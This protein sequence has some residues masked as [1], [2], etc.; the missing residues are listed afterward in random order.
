MRLT[1]FYILFKLRMRYCL[2]L[3]KYLE[4][5]LNFIVTVF[6][7]VTEKQIFYL[8]NE[9]TQLDWLTRVN[10]KKNN[11][12]CSPEWASQITNIPVNIINELADKII[13]KKTTHYAWFLNS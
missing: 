13:T 12:E 7:E 1:S 2:T 8:N 11:Q 3:I 4:K 10:W 6:C 9:D 5:E